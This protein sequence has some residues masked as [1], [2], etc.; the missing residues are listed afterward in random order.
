MAFSFKKKKKSTPSGGGGGGGNREAYLSRT[1][2][3]TK[4]QSK[5]QTGTSFGPAGQVGSDQ[6]LQMLIDRKDELKNLPG[7][8]G[9]DRNLYQ[10]KMNEF[11]N[12][13][14]Q[15][16]QAYANRF[17]VQNFM[18]QGLPN[19]VSKFMP[20]AGVLSLLANVGNKIKGGVSRATDFF[21]S[22]N[23]PVQ[24]SGGFRQGPP[25]YDASG[26]AGYQDAIMKMAQQK[27]APTTIYDPSMFD[28]T[29]SDF[30]QNI[31]GTEPYNPAP[32]IFNQE[33]VDALQAAKDQQDK[34]MQMYGPRE[35][36][37]PSGQ[38]YG[39]PSQFQEGGLASINNPE[40]NMLMKA[41]NFDV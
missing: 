31:A 10:V 7:G 35:I 21:S 34:M 1:T 28:P 16:Q 26:L 33:T 20:G 37:G 27:Q 5:G 8:Q 4:K 40:Y 22:E 29:Q 15:N 13:N 12:Q 25:A 14:P 18:T 32:D 17:P 38:A 24:L 19:L 3:G 36:Q 39:F 2:G 23:D 9:D 6:R 11:I 30:R 41:S